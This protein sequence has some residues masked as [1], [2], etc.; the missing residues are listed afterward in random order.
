MG[1][2]RDFFESFGQLAPGVCWDIR[3]AD[4]PQTSAEPTILL[5]APEL[6]LLWMVGCKTWVYSL[7]IP[8]ISLEVV[9]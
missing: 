7:D 1:P 3:R 8:L 5:Q 9:E 6:L 2:L 4:L